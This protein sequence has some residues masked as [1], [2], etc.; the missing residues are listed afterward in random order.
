MKDKKTLG[1]IIVLLII[2]LPLSILGSV[3]HFSTPKNDNIDTNVNK[4]FIYNNQV[5]FY[6]NDSLLATYSCSNCSVATNNLDDSNYHTNYYSLGGSNIAG[7]VNTNFGLFNESNET[8]LYNIAGKSIVDRY[9]S[10]KNYGTSASTEFLIN[11]K[12]DK[13]GIIYLD[14]SNSAISNDYDYIA[15][16]S[17]FNSNILDASKFIAKRG[18]LWYIINNDGSAAMQPVSSEITD[19]NDKYYVTYNNGYHIFDYNGNEYLTNISKSQVYGVGKYIIILS[20]NNLLLIYETCNLPYRK[21]LVLP[22]FTNLYFNIKDDGIGIILD[23]N[24]Y[25]T[26][27][28]K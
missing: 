8:I 19:F 2:F 4:D 22:E 1:T 13:W 25:Q 9:Q 7:V 12:N 17:H 14:F 24:F 20:N 26:L 18:N 6:L 5:Y 21:Q 15:L 23:G 11:K 28:L 16:P 27:D 10:V 3:K